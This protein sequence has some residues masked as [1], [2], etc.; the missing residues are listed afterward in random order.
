LDTKNEL[1][2]LLFINLDQIKYMYNSYTPL[3]AKLEK[4]FYEFY[5]NRLQKF[6]ETVAS[7]EHPSIEA[8]KVNMQIAEEEKWLTKVIASNT[9]SI[10]ACSSSHFTS[11]NK[12]PIESAA[13]PVKETTNSSNMPVSDKGHILR[14]KRTRKLT[15]KAQALKDAVKQRSSPFYN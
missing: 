2:Q 11:K 9:S 5:L 6:K 10:S 8:Y 12:R 3:E 14:N 7:K 1:V 4:S 13:V 15:P